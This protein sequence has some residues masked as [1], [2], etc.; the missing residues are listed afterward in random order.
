[1]KFGIVFANSGPFSHPEAALGMAQ[2]AENAGF[3]SIWTVEH[4][5]V[6]EGYESSYP[7][8]DSGRMPGKDSTPIPDP[9]VWLSFLA[10]ATTRIHLATGIL[11]VPQ[12]NP[13]VLAKEI[14]TL[15]Y[16][17]QG[18]FHLGLGI[19][20]LAEEFA[21]I[22]VPFGERAALADE[23]VAA[24][25]ELWENRSAS[26]HGAT[27]NFDNCICSPRPAQA[28]I[29]VTIGGHTEAAA[30][31]AGRL[32]AGLFPA[33]GSHDELRRLHRLAQHTAEESGIDPS[34]VELTSGG[35]G[36][37]GKGNL[38]EVDKLRELGVERIVVPSF[39]FFNNPAES[40]EQFGQEV[41]SAA[42]D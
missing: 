31:R 42:R 14:A 35:Y 7:Y 9:L 16:L 12:R 15:D 3:E 30:R 2:A 10:S 40:L 29:P 1:M 13:L 36:V 18:R 19:G 8:D 28:R 38:D 22:G 20:W 26:F 5:V 11:I 33:K 39:L 32:G 24:M 25:R 23:Y 4:V 6:P 17:S 41:I 34:T 27:V 21:A 37:F